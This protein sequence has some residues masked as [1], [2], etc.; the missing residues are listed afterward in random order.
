MAATVGYA[1]LATTAAA[2][3]SQAEE[4]RKAR[5][6]AEQDAILQRQALADLQA[7]EKPVIPLGDDAAA[8]KAR[9]RSIASLAQRRGRASTILTSDSVTSDPLGA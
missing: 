2:A 6:Q 3:A 7:E 5:K 8:K 9:R 4:A 1:A